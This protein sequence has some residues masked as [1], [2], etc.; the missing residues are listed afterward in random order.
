MRQ[1]AAHLVTLTLGFILG[2]HVVHVFDAVLFASLSSLAEE[3]Q[4]GV[5]ADLMEADPGF[6]AIIAEDEVAIMDAHQLVEGFDAHEVHPNERFI[7]WDNDVRIW[8][9]D[10]N[11]WVRVKMEKFEEARNRI[12]GD[13]VPPQGNQDQREGQP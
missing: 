10:K 12:D 2:A 7:I 8:D 4:P 3:E 6:D 5:E 9:K 11:E 13:Q 1:I